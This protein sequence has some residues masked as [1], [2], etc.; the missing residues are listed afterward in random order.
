MCLPSTSL[1]RQV[2]RPCVCLCVRVCLSQEGGAGGGR[3]DE[4]IVGL[5]PHRRPC[6]VYY[7]TAVHVRSKQKQN[8]SPSAPPHPHT[9]THAHTDKIKSC[10]SL[11][12]RTR[13]SDYISGVKKER[14]CA[15][16]CFPTSFCRTFTHPFL[17]CF[18]NFI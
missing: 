14:L 11:P 5:E 8:D 18:G 2:L 9:R 15:I 12:P 6:A 1:Q 13:H 16:L 17:Y 10:L 4:T 7:H 3:E